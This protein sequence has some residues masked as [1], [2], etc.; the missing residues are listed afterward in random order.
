MQKAH[1]YLDTSLLI[2]WFV[3]SCKWGGGGRRV[4]GTGGIAKEIILVVENGHR[5]ISPPYT[6]Q[7]G[8]H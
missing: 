2:E 6:S 1:F 4:G 3:L 8:Y 7:R 5:H